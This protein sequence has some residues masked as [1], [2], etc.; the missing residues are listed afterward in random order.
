MKLTYDVT[1]EIYEEAICYQMKLHNS[2]RRQVIRY[3]ALN[4][5]FFAVAIYY[6][7]V[8]KDY[9]LWRRIY[10]FGMAAILLGLSTWRRTNLPKRAKS[11]L[12][13]YIRQGVLEEDLSE[14]IRWWRRTERSAARQGKAG[15]K[16]HRQPLPGSWI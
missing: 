3:W 6:F 7:I 5:G 14:G 16:F 11:A 10:P 4:I 13:R 12:K 15:R 2:Q 8:T 9:P 1:E